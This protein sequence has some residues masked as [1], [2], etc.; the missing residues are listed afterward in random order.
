MRL[1]SSLKVREKLRRK[2][3]V[4]IEE[5]EEGTREFL[6]IRALTTSLSRLPGASRRVLTG[7]GH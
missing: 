1:F 2:H 4:S 7:A 6:K 5:V 3:R